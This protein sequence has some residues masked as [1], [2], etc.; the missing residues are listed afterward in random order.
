MSYKHTGTVLS[1]LKKL[2]VSNILISRPG[3]KY[4]SMV[5]H[6]LMVWWVVGSIFYGGPIELFLVPVTAPQHV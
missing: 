3:V 2:F 6:L 4:S 1:I 5:E